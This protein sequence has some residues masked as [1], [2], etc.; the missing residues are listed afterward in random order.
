MPVLNS[1]ARMREVNQQLK[2]YN[3]LIQWFVELLYWCKKSTGGAGEHAYRKW[4]K[5]QP[6]GLLPSASTI[7][8]RILWKDLLVELAKY[9]QEKQRETAARDSPARNKT[10]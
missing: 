1:E 2:N 8:T 9:E 4:Y 3:D 5:A 6:A 10:A 7:R